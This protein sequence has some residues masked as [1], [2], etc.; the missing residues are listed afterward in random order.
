MDAAST[1]I[2]K[3]KAYAGVEVISSLVNNVGMIAMTLI[4]FAITISEHG[5]GVLLEHD[6]FEKSTGGKISAV[7]Q[8]TSGG[9]GITSQTAFTSSSEK[10]KSFIWNLF[11]ETI[12]QHVFG[13][14]S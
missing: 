13:L 1:V 10:L 4:Y 12:R 9:A 14:N 6:T 3:T 11:A 7:E 8:L 5:L 2:A